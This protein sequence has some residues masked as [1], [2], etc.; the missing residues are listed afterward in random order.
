MLGSDADRMFELFGWLL[1]RALVDSILH[2]GTISDPTDRDALRN[3]S[4]PKKLD[5]EKCADA[6][7]SMSVGL[8]TQYN[9]RM[10]DRETVSAMSWVVLRIFEICF[11]VI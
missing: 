2:A 4:P 5:L 7:E 9:A 10:S 6:L 11:L 3:R 1:A 8:K